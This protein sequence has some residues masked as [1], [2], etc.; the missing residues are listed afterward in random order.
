MENQRA[1]GFDGKLRQDEEVGFAQMEVSRPR[2]MGFN[3]LLWDGAL[4][5]WEN[6]I[7][8]FLFTER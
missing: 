1:N 5:R 7:L 2:G 3:F 8:F 4:K 6:S